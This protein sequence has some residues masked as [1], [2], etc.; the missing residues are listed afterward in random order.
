M[1]PVKRTLGEMSPTRDRRPLGSVNVSP[2][3]KKKVGHPK[4]QQ[5]KVSTPRGALGGST[6]EEG[7]ELTGRADESHY[8]RLNLDPRRKSYKPA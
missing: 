8:L 1:A 4:K 6:T 7:M 3:P 2:L 5:G